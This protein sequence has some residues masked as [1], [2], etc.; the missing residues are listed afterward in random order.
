[1]HREIVRSGVRRK[2]IND[3]N[4]PVPN[5]RKSPFLKTVETGSCEAN[6]KKENVIILNMDDF[7]IASLL[8]NSI[9]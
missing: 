8:T 5:T 2:I 6:R 9:L 7:T 3:F 4:S 1:M